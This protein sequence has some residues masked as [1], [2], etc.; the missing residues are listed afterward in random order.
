[1]NWTRCFSLIMCDL[2]GATPL[3][4]SPKMWQ[5]MLDCQGGN[6]VAEACMFFEVRSA[7]EANDLLDTCTVLSWPTLF[8]ALCESRQAWQ[9]FRDEGAEFRRIVE[10][11]QSQPY[12]HSTMIRR[13]TNQIRERGAKGKTCFSTRLFLALR[14]KIR[15]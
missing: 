11:V 2:Y 12:K 13:L 4:F 1:M 10:R 15:R 7:A 9:H 5:T 14:K 3:R 6:E 8:V